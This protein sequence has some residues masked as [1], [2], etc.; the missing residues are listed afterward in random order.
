MNQKSKSRKAGRCCSLRKLAGCL[1]PY[2]Q[3]RMG[4]IQCAAYIGM[5]EKKLY[6]V[7]DTIV[8]PKRY[9]SE[10]VVEVRMVEN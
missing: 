5:E 4:P 6:W 10:E 8:G 9:R 2:N 3:T 1:Y 7:A